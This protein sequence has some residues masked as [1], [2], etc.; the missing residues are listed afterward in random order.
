VQ[1]LASVIASRGDRHH[2]QQEFPV[3]IIYFTLTTEDSIFKFEVNKAEDLVR[4]TKYVLKGQ[5]WGEWHRSTLLT[6][7]AGRKLVRQL[8][9]R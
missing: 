7:D 6:V 8:Q 2:T 9:A 1:L 4:V 5:G 3:D